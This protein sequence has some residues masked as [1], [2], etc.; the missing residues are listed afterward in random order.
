MKLETDPLTDDEAVLRLVHLSRYDPRAPSPVVAPDFLRPTERDTTGV[1][2]FRDQ[3]LSSPEQALLAV[4][5]A[6]RMLYS[7]VKLPI[8]LLQSY[9]LSVIPDPI[10]EAPGHMVIPELSIERY[11]ANK[12]S[13]KKVQLLLAQ[14][15]VSSVVLTAAP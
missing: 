3:C 9:G 5:D 8:A 10:E 6:K 14:F 13:L 15:A 11:K 7:I 12:E 1:S 4:P 2:V